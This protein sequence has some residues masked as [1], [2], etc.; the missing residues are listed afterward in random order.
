MAKL[1]RT[2]AAPGDTQYLWSYDP[3]G[4]K[5]V[6]VS[7]DGKQIALTVYRLGW[8]ACDWEEPH[9][10]GFT[11]PN[12]PP[13]GYQVRV[14][15]VSLPMTIAAAI[16]RY[17]PIRVPPDATQGQIEAA[18]ARGDIELSPYRYKLQ[19]ALW[20]YYTNRR[21]YLNGATLV[22]D[23]PGDYLNRMIVPSAGLEIIGP[24]ALENYAND[25]QSIAFHGNTPHAPNVTIDRVTFR[26]GA[27]GFWDG[28]Q[29]LRVRDCVFERCGVNNV[30]NGLWT[31]NEFRG[32]S[33][34]PNQS[35]SSFWTAFCMCGGGSVAVLDSTF[36]ATPQGI[37][38]DTAAG[39]IDEPFI[40]G[41]TYRNIGQ[42]NNQCELLSS[43]SPHNGANMLIRKLIYFH[44][45][46]SGCVGPSVNFWSGHIDRAL[47]RDGRA[48][49]TVMIP[50]TGGCVQKGIT[51]SDWEAAAFETRG[52]A[53]T[54]NQFTRCGIVCKTGYQ[55]QFGDSRPI[56]PNQPPFRVGSNPMTG[57]WIA[58]VSPQ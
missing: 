23:K 39:I 35:G 57:C 28:S 19:R 38:L 27:F 29:G 18:L 34:N 30:A 12:V 50:S 17:A 25:V 42:S 53:N 8:P 9:H 13:G 37:R 45:R 21:I 4:M 36:D 2:T 5:P 15:N 40:A 20:T 58:G 55:N 6:L 43:E 49:S 48:E 14:D 51:F 33:R 10:C 24:G 56:N 26:G 44:H 16:Q 11:I 47:C 22:R 3:L 41:V 31:G 7:A 46:E 32:I 54:G 52:E 1:Y